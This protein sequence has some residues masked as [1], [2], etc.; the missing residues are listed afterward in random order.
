MGLAS[1]PISQ[2][3]LVKVKEYLREPEAVFWILIFPV[4]LALALGIAFRSGEP[5]PI[6]VGVQDG[7]G[8]ERV[9]AALDADEGIKVQRFPRDDARI[10]LAS[11]KVTLMVIPGEPP[12]MW[13]DPTR[14]E[15][16]VARLAAEAALQRGAGRRDPVTL[17]QRKLTEKGSRYI[18]FLI[19]GLLGMNL[20]GTGMW[21]IG[22]AIVSARQ[23]GMLKRLVA[24]P[25][26]RS[27]YLV[28]QMLG[29]LI[30]LVPEVALLVGFGV[31]FFDVPFRGS[32]LAM[33]A[34][35]VLGALT[36]AGFGLL[37]AA[38]PRTI[39]GVS[40]LMNL[41]MLPMW[42]FSGIFFSN[43]RFPDFLQPM[44]QALPLTALNDA[45]R[46]V[47]LEG[48]PIQ[49]LAGELALLAGWCVAAFVA[50]LAVFRWR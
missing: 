12:T 37:V 26:R 31:L 23:K 40:G 29:R 8:A 19:P 41:V 13:F 39:E 32:V 45:L 49:A 38:R 14:E 5:L 7:P 9:V 27:H 15:S 48:T 16:R 33:S 36:F 24:S 20:M 28:G 4:L 17:S 18:D 21:G 34:I 22:F 25:M 30:L 43:S 11:G 47:L 1:H 46:A 44:I 50:A 2:L 3:T 42:L 35:C 6:A 10:A